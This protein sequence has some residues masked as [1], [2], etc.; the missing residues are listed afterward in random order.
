[1]NL[2]FG[3]FKHFLS[4][5]WLHTPVEMIFCIN[6][7]STKNLSSKFQLWAKMIAVP[8]GSR[9]WIKKIHFRP[10]QECS[11]LPKICSYF[12]S[13]FLTVSDQFKLTVYIVAPLVPAKFF[14]LLLSGTRGLQSLTRPLQW[15]WCVYSSDIQSRAQ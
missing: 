15:L 6:G 7:L 11:E 12:S 2:S 3:P 1:M 4:K 8:P 14:H 9:T 10:A 5:K 13:I